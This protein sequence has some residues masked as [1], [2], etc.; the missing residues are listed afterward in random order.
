MET[1]GS[2][3]F[4]LPNLNLLFI[5]HKRCRFVQN[6]QNLPLLLAYTKKTFLR[7]Y[8]GNW[9]FPLPQKYLY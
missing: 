4:G 6:K 9:N 3:E 8:R 2:G 1:G 7:R 5:I